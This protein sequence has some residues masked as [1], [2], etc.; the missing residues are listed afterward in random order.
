MSWQWLPNQRLRVTLVLAVSSASRTVFRRDARPSGVLTTN[1][2]SSFS[3]GR[4]DYLRLG[5][6][7]RPTAAS[8]RHAPSSSASPQ[9]G[10]LCT[11]SREA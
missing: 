11:T 8:E 10:M 1:S 6:G 4:F 3:V 5:T 2:A 7:D 9:R